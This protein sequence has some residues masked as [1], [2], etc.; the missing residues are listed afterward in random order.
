MGNMEPNLSLNLKLTDL[1]KRFEEKKQHT[2]IWK[3][4][5]PLTFTVLALKP[6]TS[7]ESVKTEETADKRETE[8]G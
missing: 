1:L 3:A 5:K 7:V 8:E 6:S 2:D 4:L